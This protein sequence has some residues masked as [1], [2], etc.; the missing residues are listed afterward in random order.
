MTGPLELFLVVGI[1]GFPGTDHEVMSPD[2]VHSV[3]WEE[4]R[5]N[6]REFTHHLLMHDKRTGRSIPLMPFFRN[7]YVEWAPSGR[8]V[9]V[10]CRCGSDFS[11]VSVFDTQHPGNGVAVTKELQRRIGRIP[12]LDNHHAYVES[13]GWLGDTG[14]RIRVWG[15]GERNPKGFEWQYVF[16]LGG[17]ARRVSEHNR[18][19]SAE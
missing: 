10:T 13:L 2:R 6:D 15:Y 19:P 7:A 16:E 8:Y 5:A 18:L 14:L 3:V 1:G 4:P 12:V 11:E 9:A 17:G